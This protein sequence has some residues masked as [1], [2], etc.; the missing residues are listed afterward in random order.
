MT[1]SAVL[2]CVRELSRTPARICAWNDYDDY[3]KRLDNVEHTEA[4]RRWLFENVINRDGVGTKRE[5]KL[6]D[7]QKRLVVEKI[8]HE[9]ETRE[10]VDIISISYWFSIYSY[11]RGEKFSKFKT[12]FN[13]VPKSP[14]NVQAC[15]TWNSDCVRTRVE[16][17]GLDTCYPVGGR[18]ASLSELRDANVVLIMD[19]PYLSKCV[20]SY[21]K[22]DALFILENV[23]KACEHF[24]VLLFGDES[25][26]FFYSF[27]FRKP[28]ISTWRKT[29]NRGVMGG[30]TEVLLSD[31]HRQ[32]ELIFPLSPNNSLDRIVQLG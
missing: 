7:E 5:Q 6:S 31:I 15:K 13:M 20:G 1:C 22:K 4:L 29:L 25:I 24:P 10:F 19:P 21:T 9:I 16:F 23:M 2:G 17:T 11:L 18:L 12:L 32:G 26:E 30:R 8:N 28:Q 3:Q 14:L 27:M